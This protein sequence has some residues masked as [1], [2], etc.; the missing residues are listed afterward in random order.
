MF[1]AKRKICA[2]RQSIR[3]HIE[4]M[5]VTRDA[6]R[7]RAKNHRQDVLNYETAHQAVNKLSDKI[8]KA[9]RELQVLEETWKF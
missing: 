6:M 3:L 9:A 8:A 2:E 5:K 1:S 7:Q 4:S